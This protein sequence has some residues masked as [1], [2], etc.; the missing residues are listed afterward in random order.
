MKRVQPSPPGGTN[1]LA[2]ERRA[3]LVRWLRPQI[4]G[5]AWPVGRNSGGDVPTTITGR[6]VR[7]G[8]PGPANK[9]LWDDWHY[10]PFF[11]SWAKGDPRIP[12]SA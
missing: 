11:P 7:V 4:S 8:V 1:Y 9:R 12:V 5:W 3:D 10:S 2:S 6:A